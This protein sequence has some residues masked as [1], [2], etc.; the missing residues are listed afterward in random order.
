VGTPRIHLIAPA[1]S[2]RRY[3]HQLGCATVEEL[4]AR[5]RDWMGGVYAVTADQAIILAEEDEAAGGRSDDI[6]R[7]ADISAAMADNDC[8]GM[9][10]L[11]GG[12]WFTRILPHIDS[13]AL[14]RRSRPIAVFGFSELT[15]LVNI[16]AA[17]PMGRGIHDMGPAF[18]AYGL[19]QQAM[20]TLPPGDDLELRAHEA[21]KAQL[22]PETR[23][24]FADVRSI[25]EGRGTSRPLRAALLQGQMQDTEPMCVI[26][27]N[28]TVLSTIV[29]TDYERRLFSAPPAPLWLFLEDYNDKLERFDRFLSHF[30]LARWWER[31]HGILLGDF[32]HGDTNL[33]PRVTNLVQYHLPQGRNLPILFAPSLGHV[34]PMSPLPLRVPLQRR[35]C[36]DD[37]PSQ[38][39]ELCFGLDQVQREPS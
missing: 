4:C 16:V 23:A 38:T 29:G 6:P 7:A 25:I 10:A 27:G 18:L 9:I 37:S 34:W 2:C 1:G 12:A 13:G 21:A 35:R 17:H 28:L 19:K 3:L 33:T 36:A 8:A 15:T 39:Y 20:R 26:G 24:W 30:T 22:I 11:R 31:V 32:H 14:D 5:V